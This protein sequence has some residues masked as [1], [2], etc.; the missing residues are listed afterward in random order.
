MFHRFPRDWTHLLGIGIFM[1]G[2]SV[3]AS[4]GDSGGD[5]RSLTRW[6]AGDSIR[7]RVDRSHHRRGKR[8]PHR[9]HSPRQSPGKMR[10]KWGQVCLGE[11]GV[12]S[13]FDP[14]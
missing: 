3:L 9:G 5:L 1:V 6:R 10:G 13:A 7:S 14:Y 2:Q 11:N 12:K 8:G 4:P